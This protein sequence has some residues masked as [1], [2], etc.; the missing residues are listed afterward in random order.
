VVHG[1]QSGTTAA[2]GGGELKKIFSKIFMMPPT[3]L[4]SLLFQLLTD[5]LKLSPP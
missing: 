3:L 1:R 4:H 5:N 2:G